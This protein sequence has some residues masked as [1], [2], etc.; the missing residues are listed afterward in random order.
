MGL[1]SAASDICD[2]GCDK[3]LDE[4]SEPT[5]YLCERDWWLDK[6]VPQGY[7]FGACGSPPAGGGYCSEC[8]EGCVS[9]EGCSGG[10]PYLCKKSWASDECVLQGH[11]FGCC[12]GTS[13]VGEKI[14]VLTVTLNNTDPACADEY[15]L[16]FEVKRRGE[17]DWI[18]Y[19]D[20]CIEGEYNETFSR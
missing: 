9:G 20:N 14:T 3:N 8:D 7:D 6:C 5:P 2:V 16:T 18:D 17:G 19:S 11:D 10:T 12:G 4:C 15:P 1:T 13:A